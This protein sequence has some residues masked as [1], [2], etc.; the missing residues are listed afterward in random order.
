[1]N[2]N[3]THASFQAVAAILL[4]ALTLPALHGRAQNQ[5][6]TKPPDSTKYPVTD[7][8]YDPYTDPTRNPFNLSDTGFVNRRVEYDAK[9]GQYYVIEKVGNQYYRTPATFSMREFLNL[10]GKK[11]ENAY[12]RERADLLTNLNRRSFK[13]KF[14]FDKNWVNRITGAGKVE[15]RPTGYVDIMA[16]YQGQYIN[17]PT[18][19]ER[20]RRTGG[21]DFNQNAQLQVDAKIGD[22]INLPINYNTLANFDFEN[23][24]KFDYQ[25]KEDEILKSF[26][27]GTVAWQSKG[28]L[29]P[30]V[31]S[32]FGVRSQLQFGKLFVTGA[33]ANQRSN[34]QTVGLQGGSAS[35][36]F[37]LRA[38][39]YEENRHFLLAQYFRSN[40]NTAMRRLPVVQSAVQILRMEVW[41]TNRTGATTD[42][43]DI[44]GF[45]DL[46]ESRPFNSNII[47][48]PNAL[49]SNTANNL[50]DQLNRAAA[51]NSSDV[52]S[53]LTSINLQPVQDFEKTFARKLQPTDY[54]Y[55]PQIGF[56]S[57][58]QQLQPD[59]VLGVAFQY[60]F[61]G[62]VYQVGEFSQD[63]PPSASGDTTRVL[64]LKLLKATSQRPTLPIWD[65]MM[66][67]VYS[68]GYG[69]LARDGFDLQ[70]T[71]EEPS[72]GDKRY[73]PDTDI[74]TEYQGTPLLQLVN[75]D[76]LNNQND[77]LPDGK[78]D[79][80]EN[81]TVISPQSR[82][83]F[84]VLEP[85][86]MDLEYV[87]PDRATA[88]KY[89][90]YPLYDTIKVI[91]SNFANLNRFKI[92]GRSKS[93]GG[94]DYQLGFN[95][96]RGSVTVT[97][98]GQ[99]LQEGLDYEINYD[100]G[101]LRIINQAILN[102]NLPVQIGYE[103]NA[104]FGL[105]QKNFLGLRLDYLAN[106]KLTLG[107]SMVK[108]G[109]RPFFTKQT[110][111]EDPIRNTMYG[112]DFDYRSD[113]P[114]MTRWLNK[115][116][117]YSTKTMSTI[118]AYGEGAVL[119]PGHA[120]EV[121]FGEG[122]VSY[123][124][125]FEG[126]RSTIDLRFPLISW[127]LASVP[128]GSPSP[129]QQDQFPEGSLKNDIASGYNRAKLAWYNIEPVL[130]E[131]NNSSNP[132]QRDLAELSKPETRRVL[133]QEIFPQRTNDFGQGI[134][135]TFDLA[136]YPREKGPYNY[137]FNV[138]P[139]TGQLL[140]PR[141][142]WGGLMRNI[143]QTDFETNNIEF[144]EFWL[145]DPF[146]NRQNSTGGELYF[147]IGNISEDILRDGKR[148]YENGL[149]TPAQPTIPVD[150]TAWAKVPRNPIQVTNAFSNDPADRPFQDVGYDG[151]PDTAER[152]KFAPYLTQLGATVGTNS[153][154]YQ[155]AV[156]DPS[157]DNFRGYR[158][159][160][161][162]AANG[163]LQRYKNINNPHGNSPVATEADEFTNAF[164][165][166]PDQE[167]LNRDNTLNE[168]EEYFQ[169]RVELRPN[170]RVGSNYITD[171][172]EVTVRLAD[173]TSRR[174]NWYLFRIPIK[175]FQAKVGNIP[176]FKSIR[177][178]R[179]FLTNFEDT[180][181]LRF[182]KLELVRNQWRKLQYQVNTSPVPVIN[183]TND[184]TTVDILAVN[185]EEND[186]R[187]P[188]RYVQPPGIIRQQQ[189][190]N[191]NVQLLLNEQSLSLRVCNLFKTEARGVFKAM[192]LDLRQYGRLS[193]FIHAETSR[194]PGTDLADGDMN[195]V[196]RLGNDYTTNY[197]EIRIP[198]KITPWS[199]TA[200]SIIIWPSDNRRPLM[201]SE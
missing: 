31:Q 64:F 93:T 188:V 174:E 149:P 2:R 72:K 73:L 177:F 143:D 1:M 69:Q 85:F 151:S 36:S 86:G 4:L 129:T 52:Q 189:I 49:P 79:Y 28:T 78:Y 7:R 39:E 183:P 35:Q 141:R 198:L 62:R 193:M 45:A 180:A 95:I 136:Y 153:P 120:K 46:G 100:L 26:Q 122:G 61:N 162:S 101:S 65:L 117:F 17:N 32:L 140:Q 165:L 44:V 179:M 21:F 156:N 134:I 54:Y 185:I 116:P 121:D 201:S 34:R 48:I 83:I 113:F 163:I 29:I 133:A 142:A 8:R 148:Q 145:L 71:Y 12:F 126:T 107:A 40:F 56:L 76:R 146:T 125:D 3:S 99:V 196:I 13:P 197:Y 81:F 138:N 161:F 152:R 74:R 109:E 16:G 91:A 5:P 170:M 171:R 192:N 159:A 155:A 102:A 37:A 147:N 115:L 53:F 173:N 77:P 105:Q 187:I 182:G 106:K 10:Q 25:G 123:I 42:T 41:V 70:V 124:D 27:A 43:R 178:I 191:N 96:P 84:P 176:D 6:T 57:L 184:P 82:V 114:R 157:A 58:N 68:V 24:L 67:N 108:L 50:Y 90:F 20:A 195:A 158:D 127:T 139:A 130:Q 172:R 119:K 59:E 181:V 87:Y 19:P 33:L 160:S 92:V 98:G 103:N 131:K 200:D 111:G 22:K 154:A 55:N 186:N 164:T 66:K 199:P 137:E 14:G 60:T 112:L 167:E 30:S 166:Y 175:D 89:L 18:L 9:T 23:Q 38:D 97:A 194:Q 118:T 11:D 104:T 88:E 144:I 110:Y 47:G 135:N 51:R 132:L 63:I 169:Y 168:S 190:S 128:Q 94:G 150:E 80:L 15:I 75:L